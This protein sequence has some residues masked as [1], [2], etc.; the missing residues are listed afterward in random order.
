MGTI[1]L[2]DLGFGEG[3]LFDGAADAFTEVALHL[4]SFL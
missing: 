3:E 1:E 2:T 4:A